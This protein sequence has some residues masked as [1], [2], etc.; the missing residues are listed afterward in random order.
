MLEK[1]IN[2]N[3]GKN[4]CKAKPGKNELKVVCTLYDNQLIKPSMD[5]AIKQL[6]SYTYYPIHKDLN[7]I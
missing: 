6:N 1:S 7:G 3:K 5:R 2:A 4:Q